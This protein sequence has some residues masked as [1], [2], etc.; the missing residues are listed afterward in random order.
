[1]KKLLA[2]VLIAMV[3]ICLHLTLVY[4][5]PQTGSCG[6]NLTYTLDDNGLLTISGNGEMT[7]SPWTAEQ[8]RTLVKQVIIEPGVTNIRSLGFAYCSN[9]TTISIPDSVS[10]IGNSAFQYCSNLSSIRIPESVMS[11]GSYA[12][13]QCR[14]LSNITIPEGLTSIANG[15]FSWCDNMTSITIPQSV[16]NIGIEAFYCCGGL[17]NFTI[18]DGVTS[19]GD[20][21]FR[22]CSSLTSIMIPEDMTSIGEQAFAY[23]YELKS[24]TIPDSVTSIGKNAFYGI[25]SSAILYVNSNS[26][27]A[28]LLSKAGF[29]FQVIGTNYNLKYIY[30]GETVTGLELSGVDKEV[31]SFTFPEGVTIIGD[32]AFSGCNML[33]T[34]TIPTGVTS[35][36]EDAFN[37]CSSLTS[38]SIPASV[39]S[40]G[41]D[42]FDGCSSLA[43]IHVASIESW[44]TIN[45]AE[46]SH[47]NYYN[48]TYHLFIAD[49]EVTSV[50]IPEGV[51]SIGDY[52][53]YNFGE[54][55]DVTIPEGVTDIGKASFSGCSNLKTISFP[56]SLT[57][58]GE[59][60]FDEC[61]SLTNIHLASISSWLT[62]NFAD[63]FSRPN[64]NSNSACHI[65]IEDEEITGIIIPEGVT[66][67]DDYAFYNLGGLTNV[68][69]LEGVTSIGQRAFYNCGNLATI[70]IPASVTSIGEWAFYGCSNLT[71]IHITSIE[72]WLTINFAN[73]SS[74][75]NYYSNIT[76]HLYLD[77]T[78]T[79]NITIP[80]GVTSIGDYAF[81]NFSGLIDVTISEG[82]TSIG[83]YA[84]CGCSNLTTIAI[85]D[86]MRNIGNGA[87]T[88]CHSLTNIHIDS[89][90]S[91][92]SIDF[93][94]VS[95]RPNCSSNTNSHL[96]INDTEI[97]SITIPE[98]VTSI[99]DYAFYKC[100]GLTNVTIPEGSTD[101]G[102]YAFYNCGSLASITI[103]ESVTSIGTWAFANC[104][105]LTDIHIA[106]I[107]SWLTIEFA[108]N[109]SHPN[110]VQNTT[111][112]LYIDDA[113]IT[114]I[115]IP[116]GIT[117]I[118]ASAF[119]NCGSLTDVT[120]PEGVT[121]IGNYAFYN[122]SRLEDVTMPEG[123]TSIGNYA[124]YNCSRLEDVTMPEGMTSIGEYAF[125]GCSNLTAITIPEGVT[126]IGIW[127]FF[128]CSSLTTITIP[129][130]VTSI[131]D[132]VFDGC[133][134]LTTITIPDTVTSFG[135]YAF[136][137]CNSLTTITIPDR[138]T[139]IG[140]SAF[141]G[142]VNLKT[143]TI[144]EN[145]ADIGSYAFSGC[146]GLNKVAFNISDEN[147]SI[148]IADNCF[149]SFP[150]IYCHMFTAPDRY[151]TEKGYT[152]VCF[153][154]IDLDTIRTIILPDDFRMACGD[155]LTLGFDLFPND[156][157]PV[158][159][160]SSNKDI[161][162]VED[163]TVTAISPGSATVTATVGTI[164]DSVEIETYIPATGILLNETELWI[165]AKEKISLSVVTYEPENASATVTWSCSNTSLATVDSTGYVTT[166]MP[167]DVTITATTERGVT[168]TCLLHLCRPVTSVTLEPASRNLL[169]GDTLQLIATAVTSDGTYTN[170]LVGFTSSDELIITVDDI[171]LV[172][173]V[174]LGT[175]TIT[176]KSYSNKI[177]T[178]TITVIDQCE[179]HELEYI[180]AK[181]VTCTEDGNT[182][183]WRCIVC[184]KAFSDEEG[185]TEIEENSCILEAPG[186]QLLARE[187][188]AATCET[189]GTEAYWECSACHT[190]FG[191]AEGSVEINEPIEIP[192]QGH[193]IVERERVEATCEMAG[194][195]T[196]WECTACGKLFSDAEGNESIERPIVI[197]ALTHIWGEAVY[198]WTNDYSTVTA[199]RV[200]ARDEEHWETETVGT[201]HDLVTAPTDTEPGA[202]RIV[203][204][205]FQN[206][207]F[208]V[209][210]Q[211]EQDIP[212]LGTLNVMRLPAG[213]LIIEDEAF[214]GLEACNAV[215]IPDGCTSIGHN[216]FA[217]C[218]ELVYVLIPASVKTIEDDAFSG[219]PNVTINRLEE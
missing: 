213:L 90:E 54:L 74:R 160:I 1:M 129:E 175:A 132:Y 174:G 48:K 35:I 87:F 96:Y 145:V 83:Q 131:G 144:P 149:S 187:E 52:S 140:V 22:G 7:R 178:A 72:T 107:A 165:Q 115:T 207:A 163:G 204:K 117:N 99:D 25:S 3:C 95:S 123:M 4:A 206:E 12:F 81:Y 105:S 44:L 148:T 173:A 56:D 43:N 119:Y 65:Y 89:V 193:T 18:P 121:S 79:T 116:E 164:S 85:P 139:Y 16:T 41:E 32:R 189:A 114:N 205:N 127:A 51:T 126:S 68:T 172:T 201:V 168:A 100:G 217:G 170:K 151:F 108:D 93:A 80:E 214:M 94:A 38:I 31:V 194:T 162:T 66:S 13:Y 27:V 113:E 77:D 142:C 186:H 21:A 69:I 55:T 101:I 128:N 106:S 153:E 64:R 42:A 166:I 110:R 17:K 200:C 167:G 180:P 185:E 171:G 24:V 82:V 202:Y 150:T 50:T 23:C 28:E 11:I 26:L 111:C 120:I 40:V 88:N 195:E 138:V 203:S 158:T 9:M 33:E 76:Y 45:F 60:A 218:T 133:R 209:Q 161:L 62:I 179:A 61:S 198:E 49:T 109:Y 97:T 8:T 188:V 91:W 103:P 15:T 122:C 86:G 58:V 183:Y 141:S 84:F 190:L 71:D 29:S 75:P 136:C 137:G 134:S 92:L 196:Y 197:P 154:E 59:Y 191:D 5:E 19:I 37:Y 124:F 98:G 36:G 125:S 135:R 169:L 6:E 47:P 118:G 181:E 147:A 57:N 159:W 46:D 39:V 70:S 182:A 112:H 30:N 2:F 152:V 157:T 156:S 102:N 67:I 208:E 63:A 211:P 219:C 34:I 215:I 177:A 10:S 192:S 146:Y 210:I 78:E 212:A 176:A 20:Y 155:S 53:F 216:A 104:S 184:K 73:R 143:I 14:K 199:T 130:G